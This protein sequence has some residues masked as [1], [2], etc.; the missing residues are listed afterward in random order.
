VSRKT[1]TIALLGIDGS[2]KSTI[3]KDLKKWLNNKGYKV[4]IVP[5]HQW[6]F[7]DKLRKRTWKVVDK[8]RPTIDRPYEPRSNSFAAIIKPIIALIDNILF[9]IHNLPDGK[10]SDIIIFDRFICATQIKLTALNYKTNWLKPIWWNIIPDYSVIF[11]ISPKISIERQISRNDPYTYTEE[12]LAREND[13]Y[14]KFAMNH[15]FIILNNESTKKNI[16]L[17]KIK[18]DLCD[19]HLI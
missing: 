12:Q 10:Q 15:N 19:K 9:Y 6:V 18:Q 14:N 3:G 1:F 7:A 17:E 4:K 5:F 13:I 11:D 16:I 8:D 2:G